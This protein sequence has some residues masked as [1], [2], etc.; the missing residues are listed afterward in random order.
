[1][2]RIAL[3]GLLARPLRAA[4]TGLAVLLGVAMIAGTFVLTDTME[5]AFE[6]LF[7][8]RTRGADVVVS[9][10]AAVQG[11]FAEAEPFSA[12][13]LERIRA[14]PEVA[15]AAGQVTDTAAV[16]GADGKVVRTGGAPTVAASFLPAPFAPIGIARGRPPRTA[17]EVALD[18]NTVERQGFELGDRVTVATER[19]ARP[20]TLVGVASFGSQTSI[21]GA[22]FVVFDLATAQALSAKEGKLDFAFVAGKPGTNPDDL[23]RAVGALLPPGTQVR[24]AA[25]EVEA[26]LADLGEG[27]SFLTTGLLAFG[28]IAVLVGAFLIFNTFSITVAQR[29]RELALLR[30]LGASRGQLLA[31]ILLEALALGVLGSAL[32]LVAGFGFAA[33]INA[34]LQA[35]GVDL[36]TTDAVLAP[37]TIV[38]ALLTGV[39][40]TLLGAVVPGLRATRV[41]PVEA[42]R[43]GIPPPPPPRTRRLVAL[44][45]VVLTLGGGALVAAALLTDGGD[46]T[47]RLTG[48]AG[49]AVA[50]VL[51]VALLSPGL[52]RPAARAVG[53]PLERLT[54][55]VGRLARENAGRNPA[56]TA[57]TSAALMIGLALVLFVTVFA[58]GLRQ[59]VQDVVERRFAGD[60]AV[61]HDDG[62]SPIPAGAAPALANVEGIRTVSA[63]RGSDSRLGGVRDTVFANGVDPA[64][65]PAVYDVDWTRGDDA[66]LAALGPRD[67]VMEEETAA[68]AGL[69]VGERVPMTGP[70]G[71]RTELT[72]RGIYR[73]DALLEGYTLSA[74]G[75]DALFAQR[76]LL[77]VL[78]TVADGANLAQVRERADAALRAFPEARAR[79]QEQLK[80]ERGGQVTQVLGLFYALL[81]M[82]V[83]ISAF[84]IVNTLTLS[85]HERT[86]E[87]GLLRAVGMSRRDVRRMVRYESAITAAIGALLGL[88]LGLFFAWVVT[89]ALADEG[90]VFAVPVAQLALLL[91]LAVVVG[92][93]AAV[94]PARRAARLDVLRAIAQE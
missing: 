24:T 17:G 5:R 39:V 61:L 28:F 34:L 32:G 47:T 87:L 8:A 56:R 55:L 68:D 91:A 9:T 31:S 73:D 58:N 52:V 43:E 23:A 44:L 2:T 60:L 6:D 13:T 48:A 85:I 35:L 15:T 22:I 89:R 37:R 69:T 75:F 14:L 80:E 79:D 90:I 18:A 40:V 81:A 36:P 16:V 25:Q 27:L 42:L 21:G 82:S 59:S 57:V 12:R 50:L 19:P 72:V 63:L 11:N 41:T 30:T 45:G 33:A 83:L 4:L 46:A 74:A 49:G 38:V 62:F 66:T 88:V 92:V 94:A 64:S 77:L 10:R 51:G 93:V 65:L 54:A 7:T 3:R 78:A 67:V 84:G 71:R 53:G 29:I 1:M 26:Q 70:N 86:R 20:F 76:R